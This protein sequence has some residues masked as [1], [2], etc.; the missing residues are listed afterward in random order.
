MLYVF[1]DVLVM[2]LVSE[3]G[4][5]LPNHCLLYKFNNCSDCSSAVTAVYH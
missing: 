5:L 1:I 2:I 4:L 3:I